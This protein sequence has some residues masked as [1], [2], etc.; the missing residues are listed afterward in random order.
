M[1]DDRHIVF[2]PSPH[3]R[4]TP[5]RSRQCRD[6]VAPRVTTR[7]SSPAITPTIDPDAAAFCRGVL[8]LAGL[9][10]EAYRIQPL[11]RRLPAC[12]RALKQPSASAALA[13][14]ERDPRLL[15]TAVGAL[16]IG[17]TWFYRDASVFKSLMLRLPDPGVA[18]TRP[19]R[20]WS[21]G[22]SDGAE[23]YTVAMLLAES[24]LLNRSS[25]LGTDCRPEAVQQ[26]LTGCYAPERLEHLPPEWIERYLIRAGDRWRVRDDL[27]NA[28]TWLVN[29]LCGPWRAETTFDIVLCRNV[30]I[31]LEPQAVAGV[32]SAIAR[33]LRPGG[34][35][36]VGKAERLP[37]SVP[38][39][40][41]EPC[42][43]Q[44]LEAM[45]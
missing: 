29:D 32:W 12:L 38:L 21:A 14:V 23:L 19:L 44:K 10:P 45:Q 9:R 37:G 27:R 3:V 28:A 25:L 13:V 17:V 16:L 39:K 41:L 11:V 7:H 5:V 31:Y 18:P 26:A 33:R 2:H 1:V 22:C 35:L 42:I 43:Y 34:L 8:R 24:A 6:V 40:R 30:T 15:R 4:R 36:V 20:I